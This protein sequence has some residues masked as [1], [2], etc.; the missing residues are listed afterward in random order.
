MTK[1]FPIENVLTVYTGFC[2]KQGV[3]M[4][5]DVFDHLYPG[6]MTLG[7]AAMADTAAKELLRQH[8]TLAELPTMPDDGGMPAVNRVV[9]AAR[10]RFGDTLEVEGPHD[11]TETA[12]SEAFDRFGKRVEK[13]RP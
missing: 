11:V 9:A 2:M 4:A 1:A 8:P 10:K 7:C 3:G 12:I 13:A 6:I 5:Q